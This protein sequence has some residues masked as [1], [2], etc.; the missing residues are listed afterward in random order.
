MIWLISGVALWWVAH[1][2]KRLAPTARASMGNAGKGVAA[3]AVLA[4]VVL[5]VIGYR[6]AEGAVFW[7]RS[8]ATVGI[9]NLLMIVAFYVYASGAT[10]PGLP[11]NWVGT[12]LR[13]PQLWGFAIWAAGHLVVNGDVPSFVLFGGLLAWSLVSMAT[14]NAAEPEWTPPA[15]GGM[16]S[17]IRIGVISI[18]V[19]VVV[20]LVHYW[21]GVTP[22]G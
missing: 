9:N 4:S 5:M 16:A 15:H 17:E 18:V 12:R 10:P 7:G 20:M 21:L 2:F 14:I 11:R 8:S 1:L 6:A 19:L 13:H 3:V 22:W